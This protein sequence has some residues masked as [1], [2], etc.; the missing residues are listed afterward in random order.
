METTFF[1]FAHRKELDPKRGYATAFFSVAG[2]ALF[3]TLV[4]AL[5]PMPSPAASATR[6]KGQLVLMSPSRWA[7]TP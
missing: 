2:L 6:S 3:F 7:S 5:F 1:C 4:C